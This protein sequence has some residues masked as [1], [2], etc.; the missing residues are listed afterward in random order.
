MT[1]SKVIAASKVM[2][3]NKFVPATKVRTASE[4][5]TIS[6]HESLINNHLATGIRCLAT[7]KHDI[8]ITSFSQPTAINMQ[9]K[10]L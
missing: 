5:M 7:N 8:V 9:H 4:A 10:M 2:A 6:L 1:V 3:V